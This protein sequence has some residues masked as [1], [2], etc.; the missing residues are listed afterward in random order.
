MYD[1]YEGII[2]QEKLWRFTSIRRNK[3][4]KKKKLFEI[5]EWIVWKGR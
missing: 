4:M 1:S 3:I 2:L 5:K